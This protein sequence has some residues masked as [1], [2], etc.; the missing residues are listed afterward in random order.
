MELTV[1]G[2]CGSYVVPDRNSSGYLITSDDT[3]IWVDAGSG[4]LHALLRAVDLWDLDA[5]WISH[6]HADHWSDLPP[7]LQRMALTRPSTFEPVPV[8][9]PP[10][11]VDGTGITTQQR[12]D[13]DDPVLTV[14]ELRDGDIHEVDGLTLEAVAMEHSLPTFGLRL[15]DAEVTLA[16]S[17]DTSTSEAVGRVAQGADL[18]LCEAGS[19]PGA[20]DPVH[21]TPEQGATHAAEAGAGHLV[22]THLPPGADVEEYRSVAADRFDG[23]IDVAWEGDVFEVGPPR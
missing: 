22:L 9:G 5:I 14:H 8:F 3:R 12:L 2:S 10:D 6:L 16:Y 1:L 20:H 7:A 17:A 11:L 23:R 4:T 19:S 13:E 18:F 21:L 15:G